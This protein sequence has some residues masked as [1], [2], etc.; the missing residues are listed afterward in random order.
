MCLVSALVR[1]YVVSQCG[2]VTLAGGGGV[3]VSGTRIPSTRRVLREKGQIG[4]LHCRY[5][6]PFTESVRTA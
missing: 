5:C 2:H 1:L 6:Q 3:D 4:V